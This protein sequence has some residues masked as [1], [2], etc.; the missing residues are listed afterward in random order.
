[1]VLD[2]LQLSIANY[3]E[4]DTMK[5]WVV[6][7][8]TLA[9]LV[10]ATPSVWAG[11][12]LQRP[13]PSADATTQPTAGEFTGGTPV[14]HWDIRSSVQVSRQELR[15]AYLASRIAYTQKLQKYAKCAPTQAK[16]AISTAHPGAKVMDVQLRNIRTS[17]VYFGMAEDG[18]YRYLVVVDAGNGKVLLD[19]PIP[20]HHERAFADRNE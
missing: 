16:K 9:L 8:T 7:V 1:M 20:T 15:D 4:D 11:N 10:S 14:H 5:K 6:S 2:N 18:E 12:G 19:K 3:E 17:L 13:S